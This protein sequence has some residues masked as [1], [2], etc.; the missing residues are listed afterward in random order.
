VVSVW[1]GLLIVSGFVDQISVRQ[2]TSPYTVEGDRAATSW[3]LVGSLL[4]IPAAICAIWLVGR[5]TQRQRERAAAIEALPDSAPAS[6][7]PPTAA[8]APAT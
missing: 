5:L 2:D 3:G 6:G 7:S 1:W 8:T 4:S